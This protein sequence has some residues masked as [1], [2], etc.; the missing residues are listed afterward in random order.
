MLA[1]DDSATAAIT[2][3]TTATG[4]GPDGGLR[5]TLGAVDDG[6]TFQLEI[7]SNPA[8]GERVVVSEQGA[9]VFLDDGASRLLS[10]KVLDVRT[11]DRGNF[12][13]GVYPQL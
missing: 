8:D 10:D 9:R 12:R 7:A 5:I 3:L 13:F 1:I 4:N 11:D 2:T 6:P